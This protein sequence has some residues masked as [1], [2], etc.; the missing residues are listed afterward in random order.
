MGDEGDEKDSFI[1]SVSIGLY[2]RAMQEYDL[3]RRLLLHTKL[4]PNIFLL[5]RKA[6]LSYFLIDIFWNVP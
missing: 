5:Y 1:V 2:G 6:S 4:F 3:K